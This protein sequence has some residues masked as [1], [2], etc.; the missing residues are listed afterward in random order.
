MM[1]LKLDTTMKTN[2]MK[3]FWAGIGFTGLLL[4]SCS[5]FLDENPAHIGTADT[6]FPTEEGLDGALNAC[7][8]QLRNIHYDRTIWLM[9]TDQFSEN[10]YPQIINGKVPSITSYNAYCPSSLNE[11]TGTFN[12]FWEKIYVG[13]DRCNRTLALEPVAQVDK[14]VLKKRMAEARTLRCLYYYYLV[15]QFGAVPFPLV[16][17]DEII[18]TGERV[19]EETIYNQ[20]CNDIVS[21][22]ASFPDYKVTE[23]GRVTKGVAQTLAAKLFLTRGYK[24]FGKGAEDF[25]VAARY[26]DSV[27][28]SGQYTLLPHYRDLFVPSNEKNKE[29]I[30]AVQYSGDPIMDAVGDNYGNNFHSK[31]GIGYSDAV[32]QYRSTYYNRGLVGFAETFYLLDCFGVDTTAARYASYVVPA[33]RDAI[34]PP[35][36]RYSYFQDKRFNA[37]FI[38]LWMTE[39]SAS[40]KKHIGTDYMRNMKIT[41]SPGTGSEKME[42]SPSQK[43]LNTNYWIEQGRD[44]CIYIPRPDERDFLRTVTVDGAQHAFYET[45][46]Y[47]VVPR[48]HWLNSQGWDSYRPTMFKFWEPGGNDDYQGV[49][50]LYLFRLGEVYLIAAEAYL[51]AGD[52]NTAAERINDVRRRAN[53]VPV[54]SS[55]PMDILP[56]DVSID[57]IL[58]E[59]TRELAGEELRWVELKRTGKLVERV[60]KYNLYAGSDWTP[61]GKPYIEEYHTLRPIPYAWWSL[62]SNKEE[63]AQNPGY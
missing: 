21:A 61:I 41:V 63:V 8:A 28:N 58:D 15:E 27:I 33:G 54:T 40:N 52:A 11:E 50:D 53:D 16:S 20:L 4:A 29:I 48:E 24:S 56:E 25:R 17:T 43:E 5:D 18:T 6:Y 9:G 44:T 59:R 3:C 30:F 35:P 36:S 60:K 38:R 51:Q 19:S 55:S 7:Y 2:K 12:S 62:L 45:V 26:A 37:S 32:G 31:F 46:N 34:A 14:D 57:F 13:V 49:R 1:T 23:V 39:Q 22:A 42:Y 47:V 10:S